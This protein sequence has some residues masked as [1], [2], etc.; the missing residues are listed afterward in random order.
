MTQQGLTTPPDST[1]NSNIEKLPYMKHQ[2]QYGFSI[3]AHVS[4]MAVK[5]FSA[6]S[7]IRPSCGKNAY[8]FRM[9]WVSQRAHIPN[10][11]GRG[12]KF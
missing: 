6:P 8:S 3:P 4:G 7:G 1:Q 10:G 9:G 2:V 11:R 12:G 5:K